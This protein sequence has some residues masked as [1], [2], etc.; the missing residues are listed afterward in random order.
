MRCARQR[1]KAGRQV[2]GRG[3]RLQVRGRAQ[4]AV[5]R[6]DSSKERRGAMASIARRPDGTYRP[7][8]RDENGK[9]HARHFKRKVDAQRWLDEQTA[10]LV[11]GDW[12]DPK[13][14]RSTFRA[15]VET[16]LPAQPLRDTSRRA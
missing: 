15:Y 9:E 7:R 13:R 4:T 14:G 8:Y 1:S 5:V 10:A 16:W 6:P 11:R 2:H 3:D 12:V